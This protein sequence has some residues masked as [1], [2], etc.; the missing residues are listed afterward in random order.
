MI[1]AV[2]LLVVGVACSCAPDP[3]GGPTG[4]PREVAVEHV[5][6][7]GIRDHIR[8]PE[9]AAGQ[10]IAARG[11]SIVRIAQSIDGLPVDRAELRAMT[12]DDGSLIALTGSLIDRD[13]PRTPA[14]FALSDQAA[15]AL[16][17]GT[18]QLSHPGARTQRR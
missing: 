2:P 5:V 9:L 7:K 8:M 1:R 16:A 18:Q 3:V 10:A 11:G 13:T 6:R 17:I 15:I 14:T 4:D 12:R